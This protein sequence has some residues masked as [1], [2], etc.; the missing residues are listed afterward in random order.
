M[1]R[2]THATDSSSRPGR[3][4]ESYRARVDPLFLKVSGDCALQGMSDIVHKNTLSPSFHR[5]MLTVGEKPSSRTIWL[6]KQKMVI[7]LISGH[8][9]NS[10]LQHHEGKRL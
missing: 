7:V 10:V 6:V 2:E 9:A 8:D 1:T 3:G 4:K 5:R